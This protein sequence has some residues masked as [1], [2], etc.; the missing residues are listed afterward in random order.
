MIAG[1]LLQI[2]C[3]CISDCLWV[4]YSHFPSN[5]AVKKKTRNGSTDRPTEWPT[6]GA[7]YRDAW[8]H[9]KNQRARQHLV[10]SENRATIICVRCF[11]TKCRVFLTGGDS[12]QPREKGDSMTG[13]A[14]TDITMI[15]ITTQPLIK[16]TNGGDRSVLISLLIGKNPQKFN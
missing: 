15:T 14:M 11:V 5:S 2:I 1:G 4:I 8:M 9:L 7:S 6:D 3:R 13:M 12:C 10:G 16:I